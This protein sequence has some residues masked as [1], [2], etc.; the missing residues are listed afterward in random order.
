MEIFAYCTFISYYKNNFVNSYKYNPINSKMIILQ[1]IIINH[2]S[3][4]INV[5]MLL[6]IYFTLTYFYQC[7][8]SS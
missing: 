3:L 7:P 5:K 8:F 6:I 2:N 4:L 1:F